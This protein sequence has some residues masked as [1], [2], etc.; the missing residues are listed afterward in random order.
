MKTAEHFLFP[1][2]QWSVIMPDPLSSIMT[3]LAALQFTETSRAMSWKFSALL[4]THPSSH[5]A[6]PPTLGY[7]LFFLT[8]KDT[9]WTATERGKKAKK[10]NHERT[11]SEG[12]ESEYCLTQPDNYKETAA[13]PNHY[14]VCGSSASKYHSSSRLCLA[15][16]LL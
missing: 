5:R 3:W 8:A 9:C 16:F 13:D 6:I 2:D 1:L 15:A 11:S 4:P 7:L 12:K 10:G 14:C